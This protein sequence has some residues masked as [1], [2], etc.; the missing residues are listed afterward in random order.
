MFK[1]RAGV[2]E[3]HW[4]TWPRID[5]AIESYGQFRA[6][7]EQGLIPENL[8]FQIGLPFPASALNGF[9]ADFGADYPVAERAFEDLVARELERLTGEIPPGELASSGTS[10]T[11]Y[12]TSKAL[13]P[14]PP[15]TH[16]SASPGPS[17]A[18]RP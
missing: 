2:S 11:K 8:R 15:A 14:G 6:L 18:S 17:S 13:W 7:R 1:I 16:G 3:L 4:D 10:V 5:D 9:K 12:S